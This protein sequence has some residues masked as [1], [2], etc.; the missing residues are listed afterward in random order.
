MG[1]ST[2]EPAW[3]TPAPQSGGGSFPSLARKASA[4]EQ[5]VL[6]WLLEVGAALTPCPGWGGSG[7]GQE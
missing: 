4:S 7:L 2:A 3:E 1:Q 5:V 6:S